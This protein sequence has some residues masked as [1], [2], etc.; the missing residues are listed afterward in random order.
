M[1]K[2]YSLQQ[3]KRLE[4]E[5][6]KKLRSDNKKALET[7]LMSEQGQVK[8]RKIHLERVIRDSERQRFEA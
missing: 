8:N 1:A 7:S 4:R 2:D 3:T 5:A 6:L